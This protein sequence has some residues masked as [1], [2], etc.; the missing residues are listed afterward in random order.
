[1]RGLGVSESVCC[2]IF[3]GFKPRL[4]SQWRLG[5]SIMH[6]ATLGNSLQHS[7]TCKHFMFSNKISPQ[8]LWFSQYIVQFPGNT[9]TVKS[10][11]SQYK[12]IVVDLWASFCVLRRKSWELSH[13]IFS[14]DEKE[15][16]A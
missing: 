8:L 9:R 4:S 3:S 5:L 12:Y 15:I 16:N 7:S 10:R 6:R 1:M 2:H 14:Q 11:E 13:V